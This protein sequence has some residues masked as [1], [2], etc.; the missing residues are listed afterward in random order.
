MDEN[1]LK[2][3]LLK[4]NAEFRRLHQEHQRHEVRLAVL[5]DKPFLSDEE[6]LEEKELKKKKLA[7]KDMMYG[8]MKDF[9]NPL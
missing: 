7:L 5:K 8:I 9:R 4:E 6:R 1:L 3:L 2:E